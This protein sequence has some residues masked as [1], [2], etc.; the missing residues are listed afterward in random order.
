M[1]NSITMGN[2]T[3]RTASTRIHIHRT[4]QA[5]SLPTLPIPKQ[6][7]SALSSLAVQALTQRPGALLKE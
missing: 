3:K 4:P 2:T 6:D 5:L 7:Q 1:A